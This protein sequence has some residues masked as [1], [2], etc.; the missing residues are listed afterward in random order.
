MWVWCECSSGLGIASPVLMVT[1][2]SEQVFRS[3]AIC[4][5]MVALLLAMPL[6]IINLGHVEI[7]V[8][9]ENLDTQMGTQGGTDEIWID[10]GQPWPQSG[11][12][13]T[14]MAEVPNHDPAGGAGSGDPADSTSLMSIVEPSVNWAYGSYAIGTDAFATPIADMSD[15]IEVGPGAMQRC[16]ESSLFTV[17]VQSEDVSG[18]DH[19]MLRLIEGEDSELSWQ[20]DLGATEKVKAAPVIVDIDDDGRQEIVVAYDAAGALNVDVW[21]PR[22][23]C[24]VTGWSYSGHSEELLWSWNDD[25]LMISSNEGPYTS[26]ILGGH[27]PTTQPLLAD[28]D[29]DG[30]AELVIAALDEVSEDPVVLALPLQGN[31]T[32][33]SLWEVSLSKGSHP[34]DPAFAQVD[35]DTGYVILT[36]IEAN[37]GGMWVWKIDSE[38]GSSTWQGGL[39]LN[40]LDGDTNSPHVRLPGPII[41]NLD[42]DPE[43]EIIVTIPSDADGSAAVDGAEFRGLEI[44]DGSQLWEFEASNGF[45]DAPPTAIDTDGDGSHDRVCWNTWWQTTTDRH[46]AAGCHN[47]EGN[48]PNQEWAQDLEQSSGNP[49]DEIAVAAPTW[50][51]IDSEDEPEL[52]VSYGR[53]LWAFDGSSGSPAGINSQWSDEIELEHRT[54]SS[55]SLAD[56]DGDATIDIVLGSMVVSMAMSDVRPLTDGRGIEFNPSAP[57][58]GEDVTV[59]VYIENAGT[60]DT[61]EVVDVALY[62]DGEKIGGSGISL[63]NPVEPSG[64]GSFASF[65]VDWSGSLGEHTFELVLDPYL[66]LSQT[67]YDNDIQVRTLSI[68]PTYN[69]SFEIPTDPLRINPGSEEYAEFGI[70]STGRLAGTWTLDVDDS[71]LPN[72]WSWEDDTLGG[73]VSV[74]I[75]VDD[76][77]NPMLRIVSP[78]EALGSDSGFLTLTLS[79]DEGQSEI[80]ANLPIEANRTRGLSIRG[81]D[82]TGQSTGFGLVSEEARAW[83][84]IENMGNAAEEQIAISWDGTDWGSN[85]RIFDSGGDEISALSLGPGEGKE[86]TARLAVPSGTSPGESVSTPL[87][88]CVGTGDEQE[89]SQIQLEFVASRSVVQ[90]SHMRSVPAHNLTWEILADLPEDTSEVNW[91]LTDSGMTMQGWSWEGN[92]DLSVTGDSI[93]LSGEPGSRISGTLSLDLPEDARPSFHLFEDS[94]PDDSESPLSLSIEVLQIHRAGLEVN[95]PTAQPFVVDVGDANLVVLRLEN[96]GNGDDSYSLTHELVLDENITADPGLE[97]SF[98][99]NPVQ[100]GAGSLRTVPISV[101]LPEDTPAR[102][103]I[104]VIFSMTS[105]G[106]GTVSQQEMVIFEVRQDHRWEIDL[107]HDGSWING[108]TFPLL[109]GESKTITLNATNTGNL[110]DDL[111]LLVETQLLL[112]GS[113]SSQGWEANGSSATDVSVNGTESLAISATTPDDSWNGSI[114]R[115]NVIADARNEVVMEFHFFIEVSRIPGWGI[116]STMADLEIDSNGSTVEIEILQKGNNPSVPFVSAYISGQNGWIIDEIQDLSEV[117]PESSTTLSFNITPPETATPSRTVELHIR[118]REG[119][120]SGLTEITLPLRVS[121]VHNFSMEGHGSWILSPEGGHPQAMV[122]NMGN[123]PATIEFQILD[124]PE[125]WETKGSMRIVLGVGEVRGLPI[126]LVPMAGWNGSDGNVRIVAMDSMG[127]QREVSLETEFSEFSWE[128]SPYIFAQKGDDALIR[129]HG[130]GP[131]SNVVDDNS[132][133]FLEWSGMGWLLPIESSTNGSLTI[134]GSTSLGYMLS[135][136]ESKV[137]NAMCSISGHFEDVLASCSISNGS[138]EFE[139]QV[140]LISD[141][142]TVLDVKYGSLG[143]NESAQFINLSGAEWSPEPGKRSIG[144]RLLDEKG[145]LVTVSER[146]FEVRRSDWNVGIGDV[147]LVG[148]GEDQ[149]INVPTKRLNENVL[150]DADCIITMSAGDYYSEHLVDMTQA[151]VPAPKFDRPDVEDGEELVVT[152]GCSFPWDIDSDSSDDEKSL[153]LSGGSALEDK[154]GEF[155]TGLLAAFLV[156]GLYLGLSWIASNQKEGKRLMALAQAAIDEKIAEREAESNLEADEED[157]DG[158]EETSERTPEESEED[159][160]EFI[161]QEAEGGDEYDQRLRRLLDR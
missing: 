132:G 48:S 145:R 24:S 34:S 67:R 18:S 16:G 122:V 98:S 53:S 131:N 159:E 136:S 102:V 43:P 113:D 92:G 148:E 149:Q 59:T 106:N 36:T 138:Y 101:T 155:G 77:W 124:L 137:R 42:S 114:M 79:H 126:E 88:M 8:L 25:S 75:G 119:D 125:G 156:I 83:L 150:I 40:N 26:G 86:A 49:N 128:S 104:S 74:E 110:V 147:E 35:D 64:S 112:S 95:S 78:P 19:S 115:V 94:G 28:I 158:S 142:G 38:T 56:I 58:P 63:M 50:M 96:P 52:L 45:A 129:V 103:P 105:Q 117:N 151:F 3:K 11:R 37:N 135:S 89:C 5:I 30:D 130:T 121:P 68:I 133:E 65:S 60:S 139:F 127:N 85:L 107:F 72:G 157:S 39:S 100:L 90:P 9:K 32:P 54:W 69:A 109:P 120:S 23:S 146:T 141:D 33:N 160:V 144:I 116:S 15:S 76:V 111:S 27:K 41:A 51:D 73:I 134:D 108:T 10:G 80:T 12:T 29:L 154:F 44:S 143:E 62:A 47:V 17:L 161:Q 6:A 31:G 118:V 152:I 93:V 46:G 20:V 57:D 14:R 153:V 123:T 55:P 1:A 91:S 82:G 21:S 13:A 87:S 66:N 71:A 7:D 140:L 99:S 22:L 4:A 81:P 61:D 2:V 70:R 84:L 97:V